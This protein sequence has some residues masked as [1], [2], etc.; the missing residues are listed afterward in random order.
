MLDSQLFDAYNSCD[1][2][3]LSDMVDDNLEFYHDKTGLAR[4]RLLVDALGRR[5]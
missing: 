3:T 2:A 1:L 5:Y 4:G